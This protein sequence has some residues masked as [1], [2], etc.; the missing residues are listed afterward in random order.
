MKKY[1]YKAYKNTY[2]TLFEKEFKKLRNLLEKEPR[3]EHVGS[4]A[5][6]GLGGKGIIDIYLVVP[7]EK[8]IEYSKLVQGLGYE[9][10]AS[11][12]D[13]ERLFHQRDE[14]KGRGFIRYHLHIGYPESEVYERTIAFRNYLRTH[15][16]DA[17][18]YAK[19]KEIAAKNSDQNKEKYMEGKES[20]IQEILK[21]VPDNSK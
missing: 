5:V 13:K 21:K 7:K 6:P 4:T 19:T 20:V 11:G 2:P 10:K 1:V 12:G 14:K 8:M 17:K 18:R 15:L 16:K 9:Y 3:I